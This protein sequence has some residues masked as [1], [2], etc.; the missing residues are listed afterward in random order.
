MANLHA[1]KTIPTR[2][3][4]R[5]RFDLGTEALFTLSEGA[6]FPFYCE[7]AL[8]FD[9]WEISLGSSVRNLQ[10]QVHPVMQ[11]AFIDFYW[12]FVPSRTLWKHWEQF[13]GVAEPSAFTNPTEYALPVI[14]DY[15][16]IVAKGSVAEGLGF[17]SGLTF[18]DYGIGERLNL[19]TLA[20]YC[21]IWNHWFRDE[22]L[23]ESNPL[24]E[25]VYNMASGTYLVAADR[26]YLDPIVSHT[27]GYDQF[28]S[29]NKYK[30]LFTSCL[31]SPQK[32]PE[33]SMLQGFANVVADATKTTPEQLHSMG[34]IRLGTGTDAAPEF[35]LSGALQTG[36]VTGGL[37][38]GGQTTGGFD[39]RINRSN[40]VADLSTVSGNTIDTLRKSIAMQVFFEQLARGGS[41]Y[42]ELLRNQFGVA[43]IDGVLQRP[44]LIGYQ[45]IRLD[46]QQVATTAGQ[47]TAGTESKT[48]TGT[49]GGYSVTSKYQNQ[50]FKSFNEYG[51]I[52]GLAAIRV[53]HKYWQGI[54][55]KLTKSQRFDFFIPAFDRIGAVPVPI[56]EIFGYDGE[57]DQTLGFQDAHYEYRHTPDRIMGDV[58]PDGFSADLAAW[59]YADTFSTSPTLSSSFIKENRNNVQQTLAGT[60]SVAQYLVSLDCDIQVTRPMSLDSN[61][62]SLGM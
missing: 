13:M 31:P 58:V 42:C 35:P 52:Y 44:E 27:A 28:S 9:T 29:V 53:K 4:P 15:S 7:E 62:S 2:K 30:D 51:W 12:F 49:L 17:P 36:S 39:Y 32:G 40:L 46:Q 50:T 61:P 23:Q 3:P 38:A 5:S 11:D 47:G 6:L 16:G 18:D 43:P 48:A 54:P 34:Q 37:Y 14:G 41:R 60:T 59:S 21:S 1:F 25:I 8:P 56:S 57:F 55:K 24:P 10:T 26:Q 33:V 22:N 45:H 20:G 19:L